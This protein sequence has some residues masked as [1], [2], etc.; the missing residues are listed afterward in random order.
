MEK[1]ECSICGNIWKED[2]EL[3][4]NI[5]SIKK[6]NMCVNCRSGDYFCGCGREISY[7]EIRLIG[8]CIDCR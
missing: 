5:R 7:D 3:Y 6:Y 2:G 8:C 4:N 1:I